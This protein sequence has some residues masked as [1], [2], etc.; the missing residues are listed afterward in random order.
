SLPDGG[1]RDNP[2]A[3]DSGSAAEINRSPRKRPNWRSAAGEGPAERQWQRGRQGGISNHV[4]GGGQLRTAVGGAK[5][6]TRP[7]PATQDTGGNVVTAGKRV[8][9]RCHEVA[10]PPRHSRCDGP[11]GRPAAS[12]KRRPTSS[13]VPGG[14][15]WREP[16]A[17]ARGA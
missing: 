2:R 3:P 7:P 10:N 11:A 14:G 16:G 6:R 8:R 9:H 15:P 13:V 4:A 1:Q 12:G 5:G 17:R